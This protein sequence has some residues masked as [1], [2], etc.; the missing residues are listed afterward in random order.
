VLPPPVPRDLHAE[1]VAR[2]L[3]GA[4]SAHPTPV[5]PAAAAPPVPAA[6][7]LVLET[8]RVTRDRAPTLPGPDP[9][10]TADRFF[11]TGTLAEHVGAKFT[12]R[13]WLYGGSPRLTFS[14]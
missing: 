1:I 13:L 3:A 7:V 6:D 12:T 9:E 14:W 8:L 2:I 11:R 4:H 5:P 10:T